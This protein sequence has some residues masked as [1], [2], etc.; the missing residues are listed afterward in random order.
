MNSLRHLARAPFCSR[1]ISTSRVSL[2]RDKE[3]LKQMQKLMQRH[4]DVPIFLKKGASDHIIYY[5]LYFYAVCL[6]VYSGYSFYG[7]IFPSNE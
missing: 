2:I 5:G 4:D 6:T 1:Y 3:K 7:M